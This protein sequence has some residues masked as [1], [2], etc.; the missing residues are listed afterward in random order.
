M[1]KNTL[2]KIT[3]ISLV[4]ISI[5]LL[6]FMPVLILKNKKNSSGFFLL[7][8]E[9]FVYK[10]I[11]SVEK[12]PV[13]E[14]FSITW[15]GNLILSSTEFSS[16]GAGLPLETR[17]FSSAKECFAITNLHILFPELRIRVSR[18]PG[19]TLTINNNKF[20]L[21]ALAEPGQIIYLQTLPLGGYLFSQIDLI[22]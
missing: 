9:V 16:Y 20:S 19:Q 22:K 14:K 12:T 6:S 3:L 11:H 1:A 18:T 8:G 4:A 7:P 13:Y 10:Y 21:Q 2:L 5:F 15:S 17:H